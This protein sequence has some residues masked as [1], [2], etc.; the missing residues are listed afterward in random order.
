MVGAMIVVMRQTSLSWVRDVSTNACDSMACTSRRIS[1][2][3][4]WVSRDYA[5]ALSSD[6]C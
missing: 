4:R 6:V 2:G 3:L 5:A 1:E